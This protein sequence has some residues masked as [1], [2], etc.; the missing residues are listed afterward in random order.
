MPTSHQLTPGQPVDLTSLPTKGGEDREAAEEE[1]HSLKDELV[2]FQ[3]RL[4]AERN[5]ALLI[6]LQGMDAAG[7]DGTVRKVFGGV[8]PQGVQVTSFKEPSQAELDHDF[9]WRIHQAAPHR[10]M[11]G[12][13]NRSQY[14]DVLVVRVDDLV[15]E[16]A[17]QDRYDLINAFERL[18]A[19]SG[20]TILKFFLHISPAEQAQRFQ[21][22]LDNP[23]KHWKF[24]RGDLLK[25][26]QWWDYQAA[27]RDVLEK[28]TTPWAPWHVIPADRKW[29]RNLAI[30]RTIV[31]TL[32]QLDP[33]FPIV[34][35]DFSDVT[36]ESVTPGEND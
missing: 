4:W 27:Y 1:F 28:C 25:R 15:P 30:T 7:K 2:E 22:R 26:S 21:K 32:R 17:W 35:D 5:R 9:L 16:E 20:T 13:F 34:D 6:V 33:Q 11:I 19:E 36:I 18:L 10:G 14:E 3:R 29:Y 31:S 12:I 24:S 8:N 23:E